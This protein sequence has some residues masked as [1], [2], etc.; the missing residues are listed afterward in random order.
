MKMLR[1]MPVGRLI[2][3]TDMTAGPADAQM[4]PWIAQLQA[5]F[6][7]QGIGNNVA[8]SRQMLAAFN[9]ALLSVSSSSMVACGQAHRP[10]RSSNFQCFCLSGPPHD[11]DRA[12][13]L[14]RKESR[15]R[16]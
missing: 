14:Q 5:F 15:R 12:E 10:W 3:A 7:P 8:N 16:N 1:R 4:Q 2:A 6:A 13:I 9:H 11:R